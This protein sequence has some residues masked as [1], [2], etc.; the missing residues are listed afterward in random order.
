MKDPNAYMYGN[1]A[2]LGFNGRPPP[3]MQSAPPRPPYGYGGFGGY[4]WMAQA[5]G[6]GY[7]Y[8]PALGYGPGL[9]YGSA[10]PR[11]GGIL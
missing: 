7:G 9:G 6:Y 8:V 3:F 1:P 2:G 4:G 5:H 10:F 11:R